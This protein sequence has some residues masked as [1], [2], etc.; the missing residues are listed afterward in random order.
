MHPVDPKFGSKAS[1]QPGEPL[2]VPLGAVGCWKMVSD[3]CKMLFLD[4]WTPWDEVKGP[5]GVYKVNI[6]AACS[7]LGLFLVH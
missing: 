2:L 6:L 7:I 1:Y 3:R 5:N 4:S